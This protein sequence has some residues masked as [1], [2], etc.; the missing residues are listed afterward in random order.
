MRDR[1]RADAAPGKGVAWK[2]KGGVRGDAEGELKKLEINFI[3]CNVTDPLSAPLDAASWIVCNHCFLELHGMNPP[4]LLTSSPKK[5][6]FAPKRFPREMR[7]ARQQ[8][9]PC[10]AAA[11]PFVW[12]AAA[13]A[14]YQCQMFLVRAGEGCECCLRDESLNASRFVWKLFKAK[15]I[16]TLKLSRIIISPFREK[17]SVDLAAVHWEI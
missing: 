14:L 15:K 6:L 8:S 2:R 16:H 5:W 11:E 10:F 17:Y 13:L 7:R 3:S 4:W 12:G 9:S 1:M